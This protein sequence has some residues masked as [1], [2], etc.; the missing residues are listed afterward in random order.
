[1]F[2]LLACQSFTHPPLLLLPL[3][4]LQLDAGSNEEV[5]LMSRDEQVMLVVT[6]ADIKVSTHARLASS[7][8]VDACGCRP[9]T[10]P[11]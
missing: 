8:A 6:Y 1:M 4:C 11:P 3:L 5:L 9:A 2:L 7:C 10:A